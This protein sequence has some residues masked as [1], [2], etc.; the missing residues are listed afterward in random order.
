MLDMQVDKVDKDTTS[1]KVGGELNVSNISELH[2]KLLEILDSGTNIAISLE[3]STEIDMT[4]IQLMCTAHKAFT[5]AK[6]DFH[7]CGNQSDMYE[8]T[9]AMGFTRHKGCGFDK[10][11]DCVLVKKEN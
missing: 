11:N 4:F 2:K 7:V 9:D 3:E 5:V 1:L 6:K 8:R 10:R